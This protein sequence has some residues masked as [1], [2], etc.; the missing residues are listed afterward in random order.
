MARGQSLTPERKAEMQ[1][2]AKAKQDAMLRYE[3]GR[4]RLEEYSDGWRLFLNRPRAMY[5]ATLHGALT[6]RK[7]REFLA[8]HGTDEER[9][10]VTNLL[11]QLD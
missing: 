5:Y 10:F 3:T 1:A 2:A 7:M 11:A 8:L 4:I 6:T 9:V